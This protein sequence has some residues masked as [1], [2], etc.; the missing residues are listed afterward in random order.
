VVIEDPTRP[1]LG[2]CELCHVVVIEDPTRP[3]LGPC[4]LLVAH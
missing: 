2:P 3:E 4:E 1:E